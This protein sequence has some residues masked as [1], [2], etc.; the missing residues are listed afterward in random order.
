MGLNV[1]KKF[2]HIESYVIFEQITMKY[3]SDPYELLNLLYR[4][5]NQWNHVVDTAL[6]ATKSP[7]H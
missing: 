3:W 4:K 1:L 7:K 2:Y 5:L 6:S